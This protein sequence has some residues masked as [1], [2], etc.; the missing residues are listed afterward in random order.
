M[1]VSEQAVDGE[2]RLVSHAQPPLAEDVQA[3]SLGGQQ[4]FSQPFVSRLESSDLVDD[5]LGNKNRY[6]Q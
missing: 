6:V 4:H 1:L 3:L 2:S 5:H